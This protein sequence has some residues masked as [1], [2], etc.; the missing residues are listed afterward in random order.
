MSRRK[1]S[2]GGMPRASRVK[3][4]NAGKQ[5][6]ALISEA[7]KK[8]L[9]LHQQG[10]VEQAKAIYEDVLRRS[11]RNGDALH[12]LGLLA[13]QANDFAAAAALLQ[14]A[15]AQLKDQPA[16]FNTLG[17]ALHRLNR[18]EEATT[19]YTKALR[20]KED[21]LDVLENRARAF[22]SLGRHQEAY[23]DYDRA[24]QLNSGNP[25]LWTERGNTLGRLS[26][27]DEAI[28][29]FD[30]AL[31]LQPSLGAAHFGRAA[32]LRKQKRFQEAVNAYDSAEQF[33]SSINYLLGLAF[34]TR[35]QA[36]D[37]RD[38][39]ERRRQLAEAVKNRGKVCDPWVLLSLIDDPALQN[40]AADNYAKSLTPPESR[41]RHR[42]LN[43]RIR[44]GY[45]SGDLFDHPTTR[46]IVEMIEAHDRDRL[47]V[48]AFS[49]FP[50]SDTPLGQ[51]IHAAFDKFVDVTTMNDSAVVALS[52]SMGIDIAVD[53]KGDTADARP[54]LFSRRCAPIQVAY[55]GFPGTFA[56][57]GI[58]Y[59]L[60]D[61]IVVPD[62]EDRHFS[63]KVLR[64]PQCYQPNDSQRRRVEQPETQRED[65]GL[66]DKA[67]VFCCLNS[68]Y[69]ILPDRFATWM[70]ILKD[71]ENSVLWLLEGTGDTTENLEEEAAAVGID[72]ER[73]IFAPNLPADEHMAR[74][75]LADLFLD[76]SPYNAHTTASDA[77]WAGVPLITL[78]GKSFASRVAAS[79]L[80][81]LGMHELITESETEYRDLAIALG[82]DRTRLKELRERIA[83]CRDESSLFRGKAL[84]QHV[85]AAFSAIANLY[86]DGLPPCPMDIRGDGT[87]ETRG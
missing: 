36:C 50:P 75:P 82:K 33:D 20:L 43:D 78:A 51:R 79:I 72:P 83:Q 15:T 59:V 26:R 1:K 11:P 25:K 81:T 27:H 21:Y 57:G 64:L 38:F 56:C 71:V 17:A 7:L 19:Q 65:H 23:E 24:T 52:R 87:I 44:V 53:L 80:T 68:P 22:Q 49:F 67:I 58:D 37:W 8:G 5:T 32:S 54:G 61:R 55:L 10:R 28:A 29:S 74:Y 3:H 9:V 84:A 48:I 31:K 4:K 46:L 13:F 14:R 34:H 69:K 77:L 45:Y 35:M 85:D 63:E 66:P 12:L 30:R 86:N 18:L 2:T 42:R 16:C 47:E 6:A 62:G 40:I 39:H 73:I 60:A 70:A 41:L 76:T